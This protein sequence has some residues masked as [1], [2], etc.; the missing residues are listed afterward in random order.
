MIKKINNYLIVFFYV[1]ACHAQ[2]DARFVKH[3]ATNKLQAEHRAYLNSFTVP[4]DSLHYY[5]AK[6]YLQYFNDSLLLTNYTQSKNL[7]FND[8][9]FIASASKLILLQ[10]KPIFQDAWFASMVNQEN[11]KAK[12]YFEAIYMATT[13]PLAFNEKE[14]VPEL[15]KPFLSYKKVCGKKPVLGAALSTVVPGLGKWYAGKPKSALMAFVLNG[16]YALQTWESAGKLGIR[17]PL[18]IINASAFAIFYLS[19]VYGGYRA[20]VDLR[21]ERKKQFIANAAGYYN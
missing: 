17:H 4:F 7:C 15:Q 8:Q 12:K 3:L 18:T 1:A 11:T 5:K 21:K 16:S 6:Y 9:E 2:I 14:L 10:S 19:N 13:E 20:I